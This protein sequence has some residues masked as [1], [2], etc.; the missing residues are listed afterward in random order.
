MPERVGQLG[1]TPPRKVVRLRFRDQSRRDRPVRF[2]PDVGWLR[3]RAQAQRAKQGDRHDRANGTQ[4]S[5]HDPR[6]SD[7][8]SSITN[9]LT[10]PL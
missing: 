4:Q 7:C 10:A 1:E 3:L 8:R 5:S 6:L 9:V 2:E